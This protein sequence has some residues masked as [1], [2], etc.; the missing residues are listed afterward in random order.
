[1][2]IFKKKDI[3]GDEEL[4]KNYFNSG[5][6]KY[7]GDLFEKH[8]KTVYGVCLFYFRDRDLAKDMVMQIFEKLMVELLK[9]EVRN[10]KAW[11]SFVV[12]NHCIN[13]IRKNKGKYQVP[14]TWLDFEVKETS[15][16]EEEKL[17]AINEDQMLEH[18]KAAM[19]LLK[20]NQRLCVDLFYLQNLSYQQICD[21]T[22]FSV[23]EVKSFIQNGKRNLKLLIEAKMKNKNDES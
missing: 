8:V 3:A 6:K 10:F 17:K 15:L 13:E 11:L 4:A 19:H 23:N 1:M 7:V 22:K 21:K 2:W 20:D 5:D 16:E 14:E 12:R 9:S 18:M